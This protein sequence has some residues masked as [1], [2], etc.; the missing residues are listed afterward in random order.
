ML[1]Y[2]LDYEDELKRADRQSW[3]KPAMKWY[4]VGGWNKEIEVSRDDWNVIQMVSVDDDGHVRGYFHVNVFEAQSSLIDLGVV[5][6]GAKCDPVFA[7]D[8]YRFL[9]YLFVERGFRR[10]EWT[11]VIGNPIEKMYDRFCRKAGGRII[12]VRHDAVML[13]NREYA[14]EKIYEV[15]HDDVLTYLNAKKIDYEKLAAS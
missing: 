13:M 11:V 12:G 5:N 7:L 3:L 9:C 8:F 2:A 14:D 10:L 6:Y 4:N 1:R 15:F